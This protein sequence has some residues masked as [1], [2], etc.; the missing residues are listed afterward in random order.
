M[1]GSNRTPIFTESVAA[2]ASVA[3][4]TGCGLWAQAFP[5]TS[6]FLVWA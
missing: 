1:S 4:Y 3:S 5:S 2:G 6:P